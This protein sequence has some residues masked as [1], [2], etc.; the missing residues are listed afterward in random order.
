MKTFALVAAAGLAAALA[1]PALAIDQNDEA[2]MEAMTN[3]GLTAPAPRTGAAVVV[4][5]TSK[6]SQ[7]NADAKAA[8]SS[9]AV[10][11][12]VIPALKSDPALAAKIES[13]VPGLDLRTVYAVN[14]DSSGKI[15]VY[16]DSNSG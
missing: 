1:S 14:T 7:D 12:D 5:D 13:E 10:A 4:I 16:V 2:G 6:L 15:F 8:E 3:G 9:K 11:N